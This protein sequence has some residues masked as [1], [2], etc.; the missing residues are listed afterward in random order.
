MDATFTALIHGEAGVGKSWL[1]D[2]VPAPR[3]VI[4][5]EGRARYTPSQPKVYWDPRTA[6][7]V[8]DGTWQTCIVPAVDF[9][10]V[11][12]LVYQWLRSGQHPFVSVNVDSLMEAQKRCIDVTAGV[13]QLD[14]G[15]WG[16]I[17]RKLE[18]LVRKYRDLTFLPNN[19]RHVIFTLGSMEKAGKQRPLLQ[20][21]LC[22]TVAYL[23]DVVGYMFKQNVQVTDGTMQLVRALLVDEQPGFVAKDN[24]GRLVATHGPI[25]YNPHIGQLIALLNGQQEGAAA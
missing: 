17:L 25:I 4:D 12:G 7:P 21:Q 16:V 15:D 3:L 2:T 14:Q 18:S 20:G 13:A 6:P 22:L 10:T 23:V 19:V 8:Y 11:D 9:D 24:T 5:L 1:A